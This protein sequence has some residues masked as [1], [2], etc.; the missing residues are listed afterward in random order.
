[1][2]DLKLVI[3]EKIKRTNGAITLEPSPTGWVSDHPSRKNLRAPSMGLA[4]KKLSKQQRE[5][6]ISEWLLVIREEFQALRF[7][8]FPNF[9]ISKKSAFPSV[10]LRALRG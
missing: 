5:E 3:R 1:M 4:K 6:V 10:I 2:A 7:S 8:F 9:S